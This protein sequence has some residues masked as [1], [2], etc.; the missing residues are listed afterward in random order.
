[1]NNR[2]NRQRWNKMRSNIWTVMAISSLG[3]TV[4]ELGVGKRWSIYKEMQSTNRVRFFHFHSI[5]DYLTRSFTVFFPFAQV[6]FKN[7]AVSLD[8]T[9]SIQLSSEL[10]ATVC[11]GHHLYKNRPNSP[12][13]RIFQ[14]IKANREVT[15][16][17]NILFCAVHC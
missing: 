6:D 11:S 4:H 1:M 15:F 14:D 16:V 17:R 10:S 12:T 13:R 5:A 3:T 8:V 9:R 2:S 7:G